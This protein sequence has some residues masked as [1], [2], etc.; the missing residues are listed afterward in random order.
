M[1]TFVAALLATVACVSAMN[2]INVRNGDGFK[3]DVVNLKWNMLYKPVKDAAL[4]KVKCV[5]TEGTVE[6]SGS[7]NWQTSFDVKCGNGLT[8]S[9]GCSTSSYSCRAARTLDSNTA[10]L[11]NNL[12]GTFRVASAQTLKNGLTRIVCS[13]ANVGGRGDTFA[14][15]LCVEERHTDGHF[16]YIEVPYENGNVYG[17]RRA[18]WDEVTP[19]TQTWGGW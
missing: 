19:N 18:P 14:S 10:G 16:K 11:N 15:E 5:R 3:S 17:R 4:L 9:A 13:F 8:Y 12:D 2:Q 6:F 7:S 1:K